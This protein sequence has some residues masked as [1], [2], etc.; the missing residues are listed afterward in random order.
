M[1]LKRHDYAIGISFLI[2]VVFLILFVCRSLDDNRLTSWSWVFQAVH[3]PSVFLLLILGLACSF[4]LSRLSYPTVRPSFVVFGITFLAAVPF[5]REPE[6]IVDAARY[7]TQ[8]KYF[9]LHGAGFFLREWGREIHAWTDMPLVPFLYGLVFSLP[10]ETRVFIQILTTTLFSLAAVL[11]YK[12]GALLWDEDTGLYGSMLL[13]GIPYLYTQV[14]LMLVD[15]PA[16]FFFMLAVFTFLTALQRGG[17]WIIFSSAAIVSAVLAK[18]SSVLM[19]SVLAVIAFVFLAERRRE[20]ARR[21]AYR[22]AGI[23]ALTFVLAGS[24]AAAYRE[25]FSGQA[26]LLFSFQ[27]PGLRRWTES[28]LS[29]FFFQTHP[30]VTAAAVVS[31]GLAV[32]KRD[33]KFLVIA[34]LVALIILLQIRRIRYIIMVFP[35]LTLMASYSIREIRDRFLKRF[36]VTSI[37]CAS[38]VVALFGYLPFLQ[39]M[40]TVNLQR[41]GEFL[42]TL[43]ADEVEVYALLPENP[44]GNLVIAAPLIDLFTAKRIMVKNPGAVPLPADAQRSSLRFTWE[45]AVPS[46]YRSHEKKA[47]VVA[48]ISDQLTQDLPPSLKRDLQGFRLMKTFHEDE[49]VF[50]FRTMVSVYERG[51]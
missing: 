19:L 38:L 32:K 10:G 3:P 22:V 8:A 29:T 5:W 36:L 47:D 24:I 50:R 45:Y 28:F 1:Q 15:V 14:P 18:Y 9:E 34:W 27:G 7:F 11:T 31:C 6:V 25:V 33:L 41:A 46:Y 43:K 48:V 30:V 20:G 39:K 4:G 17:V 16:M 2:L 21:P 13:L 49:G 40:S 23:A 51:G 44:A 26:E 42:D 12:T 35:M 37:V